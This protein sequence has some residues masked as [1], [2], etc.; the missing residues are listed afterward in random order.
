MSEQGEITIN[1]Q[2]QEPHIENTYTLSTEYRNTPQFIQAKQKAIDLM[3]PVH[4]PLHDEQH[5]LEVA[6]TAQ[7]IAESLSEDE[8]HLLDME[9]VELGALYHDSSRTKIGSHL[10]LV[11]ILDEKLSGDI[12]YQTLIDA[13]Y[14]PQKAEEIKRAIRGGAR[15]GGIGRRDNVNSRILSDADKVQV[16]NP[17]RF[18]RGLKRF[19]EGRFPKRLLNTTIAAL[20]PLKNKI[21]SLLHYPAS[22]QLQSE[23]TDELRNYLQENKARLNKMLYRPVTKKLFKTFEIQ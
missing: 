16:Y 12:A 19:E 10:L 5:V 3:S 20:L 9:V 1:S 4:D 13:G 7:Q 21:P 11:P 18:E 22:R 8:K 6:K 23:Y 15:M 14:R 2:I 17:Q